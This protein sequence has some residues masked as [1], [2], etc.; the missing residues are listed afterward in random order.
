M[1][2]MTPQNI[3]SSRLS[4]KMEVDPKSVLHTSPEILEDL[5]DKSIWRVS[6]D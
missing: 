6:A 1:T 2:D 3:T 4:V 5:D